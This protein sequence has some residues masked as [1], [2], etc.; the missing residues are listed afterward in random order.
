[1]SL[2]SGEPNEIYILDDIFCVPFLVKS[3]VN[4]K[5]AVDILCVF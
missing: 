3:R 1:V 4:V 2:C 5:D